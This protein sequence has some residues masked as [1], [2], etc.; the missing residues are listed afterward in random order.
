MCCAHGDHVAPLVF[1]DGR[2][3]VHHRRLC[4]GGAPQ[5][6][7]P[8]RSV[9]VHVADMHRN[10]VAHHVSVHLAGE[11]LGVVAVRLREANTSTT[12]SLIDLLSKPLVVVDDTLPAAR[13]PE[14]VNVKTRFLIELTACP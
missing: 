14:A 9:D 6:T 7:P 10:T 5:Y 3:S 8:V 2:H 4:Y 11:S 12:Y 1:K 13:H